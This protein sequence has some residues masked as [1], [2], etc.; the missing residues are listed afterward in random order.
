MFS[1]IRKRIHIA[2]PTK[3]A[4]T[5]GV[6]ALALITAGCSGGDGTT[7]IGATTDGSGTTGGT[8]SAVA[9]EATATDGTA[10]GEATTAGSTTGGT[11]T[12]T[13]ENA[14]LGVTVENES[15]A[16]VNNATVEV[17]SEDGGILSGIFGDN[18]ENPGAVGPNGMVTAELANGNYSV[19]A[20]AD[21]YF[22]AVGNVSI[23]GTDTNITLTLI[24]APSLTPTTRTALPSNGTP[25]GNVTQAPD[26]PTV[27]GTPFDEGAQYALNI[28]VEDAGGS[29]VENASVQVS[30]QSGVLSEIFGGGQDAGTVNSEGAVSVELSNGS[31]MVAASADGFADAERNVEI[32]GSAANVTVT[33]NQTTTTA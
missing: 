20:S 5:I 9:T 6:V 4:L 3:R 11:S 14:T 30:D 28:T 8:T 7:T 1:I 31:Y 29:P 22:P 16:P 17:S 32:D 18:V 24:A 2:R 15:G 19:E 10:A 33:L 13:S 21:G 12:E 25:P 23:N 27:N 26:R